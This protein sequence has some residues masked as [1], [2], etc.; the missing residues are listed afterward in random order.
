[1]SRPEPVTGR[2]GAPGGRRWS[3]VDLH[4][5]TTASDGS[6]PPARLVALAVERG[7]RHIAITDHDSTEGIDA[8]LAAARGTTLEV[9]PGVEINTDVP[10]GELHILGYFLRHHDATLSDRLSR[11]RAG[12]L[13]RAEGIVQRLHDLGLDISWARVQEIA[14]VDAGG[15]VGRPHIARALV[16]QG[17]VADVGDAFNRY[18]GNDG[19]AYVAREKLEPAEAVQIIRRGGGIPV[20][21]H[22]A[23]IPD[24]D[25]LVPALVEAGLEGLE[26][27]YG[28]YPP[29]IVEWLVARARTYGVVA[30][31]GSDFHGLDVQPD[32]DLG[33]TPVPPEVV[34]A[35]KARRKDVSA[36]PAR[37]QGKKPGKE[38][39]R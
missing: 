1:M 21:A 37:E 32:F 36:P 26:C 16:E 8:A 6:S 15:A 24:F 11:Q 33:G 23:D 5:H 18:I 39:E 25:V 30:T 35:L 28:T 34:D 9:I 2:T 14:G 17:L 22:P 29:R 10:N 7:L 27:Y 12:R 38:Q 4:L 13:G 20:L 31:G 3:T 19:P